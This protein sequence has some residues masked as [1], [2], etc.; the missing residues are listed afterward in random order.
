MFV[1]LIP[2]GEKRERESGRERKM[3][4][5]IGREGNI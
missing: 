4:K 5:E 1:K 2:L 3:G